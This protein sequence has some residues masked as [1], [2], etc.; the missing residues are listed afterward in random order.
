VLHR[1]VELARIFGNF[2]PEPSDNAVFGS[3]FFFTK[4][5]STFRG[6][7]ITSMVRKRPFN[8]QIIQSN[9]VEAIEELQ[10]LERKATDGTLDEV[11]LHLGLQHA[12]H[13]LNFAWNVRRISTS[14]YASVTDAKFNE[15]GKYPA[16]IEQL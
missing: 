13:H 12:Y 16:E 5:D 9:I 11:G 8:L 1:P 2:N 10:K 7:R 3:L 14:E 6:K 15:W 4:I